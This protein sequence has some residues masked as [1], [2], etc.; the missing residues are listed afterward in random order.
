M[1]N[2]QFLQVLVQECVNAGR[3]VPPLVQRIKEN[4]NAKNP[5][6]HFKAVGKIIVIFI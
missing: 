5:V 3:F 1:Y 4:Q 2:E 6:D